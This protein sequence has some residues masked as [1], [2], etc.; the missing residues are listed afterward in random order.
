MGYAEP[1]TA[2]DE[3]LISLLM[4]VW[5][6]RQDW[7]ETAV[8]SALGQGGVQ[9]E[10]VII[11]DGNDRPVADQLQHVRDPRLRVERIEHSGLAGARNAAI[12]LARGN[13]VRF[14][15]ADDAFPLDG[16]RLLLALTSGRDDVLAYGATVV[17]DET[18]RPIWRMTAHQ[19][20]DVVRDS[21]LGRFNVRIGGLLWPR[22]LLARTGWFDTTMATS[23]DWEYIQR[24][25][26][27]ATVRGTTEVVLLYRRHGSSLTA[28]ID[29]GRASARRI[30][31]RYFERHPEQRGTRLEHRAYAMLDATAARVYATHGQPRRAAVHL[32]RAVA[33]DPLCVTNEFAQ[34]RA[35]LIGRLERE[36]RGGSSPM[37]PASR[38]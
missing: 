34:A 20:G 10:L 4:T 23:S 29:S 14:V 11:D 24:A 30:V 21:L 17:C 37:R 12:K 31:D 38:S 8:A 19:R 35:A 15:D 18:L 26:E 33:R 3:R 32:A 5:R 16:T 22:E 6:P 9:A 36:L 7:L 27:L 13:Y 25:V 1:A 28:N 2:R